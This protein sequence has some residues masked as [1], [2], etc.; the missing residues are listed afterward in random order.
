MSIDAQL[1]SSGPSRRKPSHRYCVRKYRDAPIGIRAPRDSPQPASV[2]RALSDSPQ[3]ATSKGRLDRPRTAT[4][5]SRESDEHT[6]NISDAP[7]GV[8]PHPCHGGVVDGFES[9]DKSVSDID[10]KARKVNSERDGPGACKPDDRTVLSTSVNLRPL[11]VKQTQKHGSQMGQRVNY[12]KSTHPTMHTRQIMSPALARRGMS[13]RHKPSTIQPPSTPITVSPMRKVDGTPLAPRPR[14]ARKIRGRLSFA[15]CSA[16]RD[17]TLKLF[18]FPDAI[19]KPCTPKSDHET[20]SEWEQDWDD[21]DDL[22]SH[23]STCNLTELSNAAVA[24]VHETQSLIYKTRHHPQ[25]GQHFHAPGKSPLPLV[26]KRKEQR[27]RVIIVC[28]SDSDRDTTDVTNPTCQPSQMSGTCQPRNGPA[29]RNTRSSR[30]H[31]VLPMVVIPQISTPQVRRRTKAFRH[32]VSPLRKPCARSPIALSPMLK[33]N[34]VPLALTRAPVRNIRGRISMVTSSARRNT[35]RP[36][37]TQAG[38]EYSSACQD[39]SPGCPDTQPSELEPRK[40][41]SGTSG[42]TSSMPAVGQSLS[43]RSCG[44]FRAPASQTYDTYSTPAKPT[45]VGPHSNYHLPSPYVYGPS[46]VRRPVAS[47]ILQG[48]SSL[49]NT[50][51]QSAIYDFDSTLTNPP[52]S[53]VNATYQH[54]RLR[55]GRWSKIAEA[56]FSEVYGWT[57]PTA[58]KASCS[59]SVRVN[60]TGAFVMKVVP[61]K[62]STKASKRRMVTKIVNQDY[63]D[64]KEGADE[65]PCETEWMDAEKEIKL[66]QLLGLTSEDGF[67]DFRG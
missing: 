46:P 5:N 66:A 9:S 15:T 48:L 62:R 35:F 45:L 61:I 17:R 33:I 10:F 38:V 53:I 65:F 2:K 51:G 57:P 13:P 30:A 25:T 50:C 40:V 26:T 39:A 8:R 20:G 56:T 21:E 19:L 60:T 4:D 28:D 42:R 49:L 11:R 47:I 7:P 29:N 27:R 63:A 14:A 44:P 32:H 64:T 52:R 23:M 41:K 22:Q 18:S 37:M 54:Q 31:S 58:P 24:V 12:S 16:R 34:G 1:T 6:S 55:E 43:D 36:F 59:T 3:P 67:I